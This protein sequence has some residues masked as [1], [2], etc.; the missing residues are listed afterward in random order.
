[1]GTVTLGIVLDELGS[2]GHVVESEVGQP[3][4]T[5]SK[6]ALASSR[7]PPWPN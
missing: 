4:F 2:R 7:E 5:H 3:F 1:M 6:L